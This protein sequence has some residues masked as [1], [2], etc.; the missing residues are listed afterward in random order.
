MKIRRWLLLLG[1]A[2]TAPVAV[3]SAVTPGKAVE[4]D[5]SGPAGSR[6][7]V[8]WL[9]AGYS[10]AERLPL[11]V[12]LHGCGQG[13]AQFAGLTRLNQ[14]ADVEKFLVL[15]P[16]QQLSANLFGC[17]N[18]FEPENQSRGGEAALIKGIVDQVKESYAVDGARV[19][20]AGLSAGGLMT[21]ILLSC[22]P[23]V[24]AAGMIASGGMYAAA[25]DLREGTSMMARGSSHDPLARGRDALNCAGSAAARTVP[26][27]VIHGTADEIVVPVNAEQ[28][29]AQ[30]AQTNDLTDDGSDNDS[31]RNEATASAAETTPDGLK[32]TTCDYA[33]GGK[34]L[35]Q[36]LVVEGMGHAWSGGDP[37]F[38]FAE[39]KGPDATALVWSFF[40]QHSR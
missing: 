7:Y 1:S 37:A 32:Y 13:A 31:V 24:F 23:D 18:W 28:A 14:R 9:P 38:P 34:L 25:T 30:F 39:P 22:Y 26:V 2:I 5:Y 20:A 19:Y 15:Y 21:S 16:R 17:W 11:V 33:Y 29:I 10:A 4:G 3:C 35:M 36:S 6:E 27:L 12:A 40:R 8:L